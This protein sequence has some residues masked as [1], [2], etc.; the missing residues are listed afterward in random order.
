[1][2]RIYWILASIGILLS[3][4]VG[5]QP[6]A[7]PENDSCDISDITEEA[8]MWADSVA[9]TMSVSRKAAQ[10][11]MPAVYSSDD[12][13]TLRLIR[14]YAEMGIGGIVLLK[15][16]SE[17][18]KSLADT[19]ERRSEVPTFV[20]I[21]AEWGLAM[22]LSDGIKFPANG[23]I[24]E[25]ADDQ[26]MYDYGREIARECRAL[27]IN[28]VLGPV[29]DVEDGTGFIGKRSLGADVKRVANLSVAYARGLEGG[30]VISVAKHFPGHGSVAIDSHKRKGVIAKSLHQLDSLD[31]YPFKRWVEERLSGVMVGHLAVPSI[32]SKMLPAVV[33]S[34]VIEDLLR[35]DLGFTGLVITDA[36]NMGGAEGYGADKA[37]GAGADIVIAPADTRKALQQIVGAVSEGTV[38]EGVLTERVSR[39]LF[40]KYLFGVGHRTSGGDHGGVPAEVIVEKLRGE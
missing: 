31:L 5:S 2:N 4:C 29:V 21:D 37:V 19:L 32:D 17:G 18:A 14:E 39:I 13:W 30:G 34:T 22:R 27:G 40:Y 38:S 23:A 12:E 33:S 3:S 35:K 20:A 9:G 7:A 1:M 8:R 25:G 24:S 11:L 16:D 15:G 10:M 28:M 6:S 36:L 26:T